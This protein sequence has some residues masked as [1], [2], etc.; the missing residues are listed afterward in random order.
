MQDITKVDRYDLRFGTYQLTQAKRQEKTTEQRKS[1]AKSFGNVFV[2]M[3]EE[4]V[5]TSK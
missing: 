5:V 3:L 1:I 2:K 4:K